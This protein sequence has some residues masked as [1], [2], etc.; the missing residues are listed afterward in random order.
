M[1]VFLIPPN[2]NVINILV[3]DGCK[4][5]FF[6]R[7]V[8]SPTLFSPKFIT[9]K[10]IRVLKVKGA[11]YRFLYPSSPLNLERVPIL[12]TKDGYNKKRTA[13]ERQRKLEHWS[14]SPSQLFC[15]DRRTRVRRARDVHPHKEREVYGTTPS[16][17]RPRLN[18][19][20]LES[21][22]V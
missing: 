5:Q 11:R 13:K 15:R 7:N 19:H 17:R 6:Y 14:L 8:S 20:Y 3:R 16:E 18:E 22:I 21:L 9:C 4:M 2:I 12:T 1:A 10:D